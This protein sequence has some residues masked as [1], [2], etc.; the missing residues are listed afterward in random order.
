MDEVNKSVEGKNDTKSALASVA[1]RTISYL[2]LLLVIKRRGDIVH[3]SLL[4]V[5]GDKS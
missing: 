2:E 1:G 4:P 5:I 3:K